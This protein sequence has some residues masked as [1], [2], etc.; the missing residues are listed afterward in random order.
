MILVTGATGTV[1]PQVIREL[2]GQNTKFRAGVHNR[3]LEIDGVETCYIDYDQPETLV[4]AFHDVHAVFLVLPSAFNGRAMLTAARNT[5]DVARRTGVEHIVK[6]SAYGA[7]DEGYTHA[8]WHRRVEREIERSGLAWTFLRPNMIMQTVLDDWGESIRTENVFC[9][10]VEDGYA[11]VDARDVARVAAHVLTESG[12]VGKAYELTGP[13]TISL[14]EMA[15]TFT[16]VLDRSI[17]Y[18]PISHEDYWQSL[19]DSGVSEEMAEAYIDV[20]QYVRS[21]P[22][23]VTSSVR[24]VTGREPTSFEEFCCDHASALTAPS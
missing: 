10:P 18:V 12:H 20:H 24:D 15:E 1:S 22:S 14:D 6:L 2:I 7:G 3:P 5:I 23:T 13:A 17:R 11:P 4:P 8:R 16:H 9:Y 19:L 21:V